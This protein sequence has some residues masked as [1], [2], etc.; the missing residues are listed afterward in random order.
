M[1]TIDD[2]LASPPLLQ[3]AAICW[4]HL[5]HNVALLHHLSTHLY[6]STD[7]LEPLKCFY[8]CNPRNRNIGIRKHRCHTPHHEDYIVRHKQLYNKVQNFHFKSLN[9]NMFKT[10]ENWNSPVEQ[11]I[12]VY[13]F[14]HSQ[15]PFFRHFPFPLQLVGQDP[16]KIR[17]FYIMK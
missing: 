17:S 4:I 11:S 10:I 8:M 2:N 1:D 9:F 7:F 13:P 5:V 6:K 16:E 3:A 12:P 14:L 15:I